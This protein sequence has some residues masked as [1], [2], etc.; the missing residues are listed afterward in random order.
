M[1]FMS[2]K[3]TLQWAGGM[4]QEI[5]HPSSRYEALSSNSSITK[6]TPHSEDD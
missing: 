5:E 3:Y 4:V 2:E 1:I 6:K